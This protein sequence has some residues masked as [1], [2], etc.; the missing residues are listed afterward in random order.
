MGILPMDIWPREKGWREKP[1]QRLYDEHAIRF[2]EF[3]DIGSMD[4]L[5]SAAVSPFPIIFGH[6]M[7][8]EAVCELISWDTIRVANSYSIDWGD[9]GLHTMRLSEVELKRYGAW[10]VIAATD[11]GATP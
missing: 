3:L 4:E 5:R 8:A 7:H 2:P 9:D 10:A 11:P 6:D 1:P